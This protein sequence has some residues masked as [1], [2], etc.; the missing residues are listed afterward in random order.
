MVRLFILDSW[1]CNE[2]SMPDVP[3][4]AA[5]PAKRPKRETMKDT[6]TTVGQTIVSALT[7][8]ASSSKEDCVPVEQVLE[9]FN[10]CRDDICIPYLDDAIRIDFFIRRL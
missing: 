7:P 2:E 4:F 6:L 10:Y 9:L 1:N 3:M 5:Y 8:S